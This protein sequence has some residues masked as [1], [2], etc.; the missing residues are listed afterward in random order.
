MSAASR[1]VP[2]EGAPGAAAATPAPADARVA[3]L[4]ALDWGTSNLRASLLGE[5]GR[6]IERRSAPGGVMAVSDGRF[7]QALREVCGDWLGQH[8]VPLIASGMIGSRQG[9]RE[10]PYVAC[11]AAARELSRRLTAVPLSDGATTLHIVPGLHCIGDDGIDDVMRGE[12]TQL[13]G[14]D[15]PAFS[16]A[17]LPGT[18]SKWAWTGAAGE[19]VRFQTYMT[20]ELYGLLTRHSILGR[21][22]AFGQERLAEFERGARIGLA[23]HARL[24]HIVFAA[25]TAGL[26]GRTEPEGL[27]DFLSGLLV[28]AEIGAA[29][30]TAAA[31]PTQVVL[32]G[33]ADLCRRYEAGLKLAGVPCSRADE[34]V[35]TRGQW[36]LA[37][38]AGLVREDARAPSRGRESSLASRDVESGDPEGRGASGA[39]GASEALGES[40]GLRHGPVGAPPAAREASDPIEGDVA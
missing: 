8:D 7:E 1:I 5:R 26:M 31:R 3:R 20:G 22:M 38:A 12:E 32:I 36:R 27:P 15:L 9:W 35:T 16:C 40:A 2:S 37:C 14:A 24:T 10:A 28:G 34:D 17:V 6:L 4:I 29:L 13:W 39:P 30:G 23:E 19:I 11:P 21:L 33:E 18:H 25:R